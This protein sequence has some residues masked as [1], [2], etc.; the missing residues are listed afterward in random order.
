M[1]LL[2]KISFELLYKTTAHESATIKMNIHFDYT[3]IFKIKIATVRGLY[4]GCKDYKGK[5]CIYV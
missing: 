4:R 2:L 1:T 5:H 3:N